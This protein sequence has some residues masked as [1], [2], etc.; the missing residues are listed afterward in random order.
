MC[1][2]FCL[3]Q[4]NS[5]TEKQFALAYFKKK[6][7]LCTIF[8]ET[9]QIMR[10][11]VAPLNWGLGHASR[12]VPLI[13]RLQAEGHEV[14]L[15]GDGESLTL[16]R[17]HF[18]TL[19]VLPLAPLNLCYST[20]RRQVFAM[21]RALP[22]IIHAAIRDHQMLAGYLLYEQIDEVISDNR[23]G[24]YNTKTHCIYMTHQLTIALPYPWRWLEPLVARWHKRIINRF[25]ECWIPDEQQ[26]AMAGRL[27]HPAVLPDNAKFIGIL[28]R[29]AGKSFTPNST[30]RVVA[31]LSGL[32]PQRTMFEQD[33]IRHYENA[34]E[35]VL[36]VRGKMHEP[37]TVIKHGLV[38]IAPL[39]DDAHLAAYLLGAERIICRSGY[40]SV[41]DMY[42][43]GVMNKVEWHPTP[44]QPEQEYL[45]TYIQSSRL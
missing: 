11:L 21:L 24:L 10:I 7:Y 14:V 25:D 35:T 30:F 23:F 32:E 16:L 19:P 39:L 5:C 22:Q 2:F 34:D 33:I 45:A 41:M 38:T 4:A 1:A 40:S 42:A 26:P 13:E 28:S 43:L 8:D 31:V 36:I 18:P 17:K 9:R 29:F 12:C 44:G 3:L 20:G 15:G 37:P 6:L 27:S